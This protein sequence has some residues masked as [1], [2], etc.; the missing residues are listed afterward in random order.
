[1]RTPTVADATLSQTAA[2]LFALNEHLHQ[3]VIE[4]LN[5]AAWRT[6]PPG[7]VRTIAAIFTHIH[8]IR[9]KWIRLSAPF[10]EVPPQLNRAHCT[11]EK[12]RA[13]LAA[14]ATVCTAML[15]EALQPHSRIPTFR[16]DAW[17]PP[18]PAGLEM[19]TYMLT[20]EA[21]HRGQVCLLAH[22]LGFPLPPS[23]GSSLWKW[24]ALAPPRVP[25]PPS[26][27]PHHLN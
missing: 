18:W 23:V 6:Q 5:A 2:H 27:A 13:G 4:H 1:M 26:G 17:A 12:A 9:C 14:S 11:P 16:R 20:H 15:T 19:L 21:H 24:E 7:K 22:Q 10:L 25:K 8:N 3:A